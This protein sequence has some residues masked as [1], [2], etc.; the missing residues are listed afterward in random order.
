MGTYSFIISSNVLLENES[1][2]RIFKA[3][4]YLALHNDPWLGAV[5]FP[6]YVSCSCYLCGCR[7]ALPTDGSHRVARAQGTSS[8]SLVHLVCKDQTSVLLSCECFRKHLFFEANSLL[9]P[10]CPL[11]RHVCPTYFSW[12]LSPFLITSSSSALTVVQ[13]QA[14]ADVAP[15]SPFVRQ[16]PMPRS[17]V[18]A[19][20]WIR[21]DA[22][23]SLEIIFVPQI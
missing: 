22:L 20:V 7:C 5:C 21:W 1:D 8:L 2:L 4:F 12:H 19:A 13:W 23:I 10:L 18:R 15:R 9:L 11:N 17:A 3:Y 14:G 6:Q 16:K